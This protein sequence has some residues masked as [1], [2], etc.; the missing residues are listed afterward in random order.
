[1]MIKRIHMNDVNIVD[2]QTIVFND[3]NN[4][5][6]TLRFEDVTNAFIYFR[7]NASDFLGKTVTELHTID[8]N[9][10][11]Y[12]NRYGIFNK[13]SCRQSKEKFLVIHD[14]LVKYGTDAKLINRTGALAKVFKLAPYIGS[15]VL[16]LAIA[17][18]IAGINQLGSVAFVNTTVSVFGFIALSSAISKQM[19][20]E[21]VYYSNWNPEDKNRLLF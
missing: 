3:K 2:G 11:I 19:R 15:L 17:S 21:E 18:R 5:G 13:A 14:A 10:I 20:Y 7:P 1:M 12:W 9:Y 16:L 4:T 6:S 8:I